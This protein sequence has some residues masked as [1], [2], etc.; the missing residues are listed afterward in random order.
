MVRSVLLCECVKLR[1]VDVTDRSPPGLEDN[2]RS[3]S[4]QDSVERG[5]E[6]R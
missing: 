5:G 4:L 1:R 2:T 3:E 6:S